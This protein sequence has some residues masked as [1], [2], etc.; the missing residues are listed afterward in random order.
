MKDLSKHGVTL[1]PN[2]EDPY[3]KRYEKELYQFQKDIFNNSP[4]ASFAGS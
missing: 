3:H 1:M 4:R 2:Y